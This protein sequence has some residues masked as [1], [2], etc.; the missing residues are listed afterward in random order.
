MQS[1][2][3]HRLLTTPR[4]CNTSSC[5]HPIMHIALRSV[6]PCPPQSLQF[7]SLLNFWIIFLFWH[8]QAGW[9]IHRQAHPPQIYHLSSNMS[10]L[11][12]QWV[13]NSDRH[14]PNVPLALRRFRGWFPRSC[15]VW[16]FSPTTSMLPDEEVSEQNCVDPLSNA[17]RRWEWPPLLHAHHD[18]SNMSGPGLHVFTVSQPKK[19]V[20]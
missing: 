6:C 15:V 11:R 7:L 16:V 12:I 9:H 2:T 14:S 20:Q 10:L 13:G 5:R 1:H 19:M 4:L 17:N 3:T 8:R 18:D